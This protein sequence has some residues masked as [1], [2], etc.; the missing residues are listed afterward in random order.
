MIDWEIKN[1]FYKYYKTLINSCYL[2]TS[3][4]LLKMNYKELLIKVWILVETLF[5]IECL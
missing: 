1:Y 4:S 3:I 5:K 2:I